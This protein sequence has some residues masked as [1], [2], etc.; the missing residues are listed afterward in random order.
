MAKN[1]TKQNKKNV[2]I[3]VMAKNKTKQ[4]KKKETKKKKQFGCNFFMV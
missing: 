3:T 1:K 4:K 2:L